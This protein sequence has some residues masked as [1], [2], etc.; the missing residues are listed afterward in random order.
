MDAGEMTVEQF[1]AHLKTAR[2]RL[3][4]FEHGEP[5][6]N[7]RSYINKNSGSLFTSAS[8]KVAMRRR[9]AKYKNDR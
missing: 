3:I 7:N 9:M 8:V 5:G 6:K 4:N 2:D 1:A